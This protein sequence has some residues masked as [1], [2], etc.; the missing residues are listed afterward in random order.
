[1]RSFID[2]RAGLD[3]LED[4][5]PGFVPAVLLEVVNELALQSVEEALHT[6][7]VIAVSFPRHTGLNA[8]LYR[9]LLIVSRGK[10][11]RVQIVVFLNS[12]STN[13]G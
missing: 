10:G 2:D 1:M 11:T 5:E 9:Y 4:V 7:I 12:L 6:S 3:V 13:P 8:V